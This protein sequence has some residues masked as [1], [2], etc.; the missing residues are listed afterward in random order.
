MKQQEVSQVV[1]SNAII[2]KHPMPMLVDNVS[3][4]C[5]A[6]I[7]TQRLQWLKV[8]VKALILVTSKVRLVAV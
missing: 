4:T 7:A 8:A 2:S 5:E 3:L 1:E 6:V